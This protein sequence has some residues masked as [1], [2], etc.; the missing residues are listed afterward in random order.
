[1]AVAIVGIVLGPIYI[2]QGAVFDRVIR[3]AESVDRMLVA[4]DVFVD[5][6]DGDENVIKKTVTDP[7]TD[8]VYEK[9]EPQKSS[10]LAKEFNHLFI[11]KISWHWKY[12]DTSYGD[13]LMD[14]AFNPPE[15]K[16]EPEQPLDKKQQNPEGQKK[17]NEKG[18]EKK[19]QGKKDEKK[20]TE[21][22]KS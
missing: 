2:L 18:G 13:V 10:I 15:Q 9:K 14:I 6:K 17:D 3:M 7:L 16:E 1:L 11:K 8:I 5:V 20:P 12:Q 21:V 22:K 4:Y 19:E